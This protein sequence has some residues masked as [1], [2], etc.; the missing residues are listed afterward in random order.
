MLSLL[1]LMTISAPAEARLPEP[2]LVA[3]RRGDCPT[4]LR[5][6]SG[7]SGAEAAVAKARCGDPSG[8]ESSVGAGGA[9][10]PYARLLLA[11]S[12]L[13]KDDARAES[14]LRGQSLPGAAGLRLRLV[15]DRALINLG[16]SL[17]AREDLRAL[18]TT[19]VGDEAL[20]WLSYGAETRGDKVAAIDGYQS[21]WS[22]NV[23]SPFADRCA[24]RLAALGAPVPDL[25]TSA[26]R[27]LAL[28]R[29]RRLVKASRADEAI[30]LF[31]GV[32]ANGGGGGAAWDQE[33]ARALFLAKDYP[34][35][36]A[37]AGTLKLDQ[38]GA[39]GGASALFDYALGTSRAGDYATAAARYQRLIELYPTSKQAVTASFKIAYLAYDAGD[40]QGAIP[41]FKAHLKAYPSSEHASEALWFMGWAAYRADDLPAA[42][43]HLQRLAT[44]YPKSELA[45]GAAYWRARIQGREG[46]SAGEKAAL[47]RLLSTWPDSGH[48][49]FAAER[50]GRRFTGHGAVTAPTLSASFLAD[51]PAAREALALADAGQLDWARERLLDAVPSGADRA[52]TLA[53][54]WALI[55]VGALQ[56][57]QRLARPYCVSPWRDDADP[58]ALYACTPRPEVSVVQEAAERAGLEPLLP[59]AIMTAESGLDPSARSIAGALGLMQLMP[60]LGEELS[61]TLMPGAP[62]EPNRLYNVGFNAWLGTT[63]LGRL[64]QRFRAKGVSPSLPL[65]IAGYNGGADAVQRWLDGYTSP[66]EADWF[67]ENIS[68]TETRRYV[69]RVLGYLMVYRWTYGDSPVKVQPVRAGTTGASGLP[70]EPSFAP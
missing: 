2:A 31:D 15:R 59:Y 12:L 27:A 61:A 35:Y 10:E 22:K 3:L 21:C 37:L 44:S 42:K 25:K 57:G 69:K 19:S 6:L 14:L 53:F 36:V 16:K 66:P 18:T 54:A 28:E 41:L 49:F 65:V 13:G 39:S 24:E 46:D 68:Y 40:L 43:D 60:T 56:D 17:D 55:D 45:P 29:A 7:V 26:G 5:A 63:E 34:R 1:T 33:L 67:A 20:Y 52:T 38:P 48:A 23:S 70:T 30:P 50:L 8:L 4:A 58:V 51:N 11:E 64:H 62:F 47:E 32:A 9:L